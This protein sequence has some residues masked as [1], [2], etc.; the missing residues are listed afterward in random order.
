MKNDQSPNLPSP[1][2]VVLIA[3]VGNRNVTYELAGQ[4]ISLPDLFKNEGLHFDFRA[5]TRQLVQEWSDRPLDTLSPFGIQIF[6]AHLSTNVVAAHLFVT[7]QKTAD[8]P[9]GHHQDTLYAGEL[10]QRV[11]TEQ[12]E[13]PTT[14]HRYTGDPTNDD[15]V[16]GFMAPELRAVVA[17][18]PASEYELRFV[19]AGGTPG[20]K[21]VAKSLLRYY[22]PE[23]DIVY[24]PQ[25]GKARAAAHQQHDRYVLLSVARQFVHTYQYRAAHN[26][27]VSQASGALFQP[28]LLA[29]LQVAAFRKTFN[30]ATA[31]KVGIGP[32]PAVFTDY[33][34]AAPVLSKNLVNFP[35]D[36]SQE[37]RVDI[38][39]LASLTALHL[40]Q[41]QYEVAI[42]TYYRLCEEI[43]QC[44]AEHKGFSLR[45]KNDK[46][47]FIA[48]TQEAVKKQY[49]GLD[50]YGVPYLLG[51]ALATCSNKLLPVI[52]E[53]TRTISH[54]NGTPKRH[55]DP[56]KSQEEKGLNVLR[57]DCFL[58]HGNRPITK[59]AIEA[60]SPGFLGASGRAARI[61]QLLGLP[62]VNVYDQMNTEI[63]SLFDQE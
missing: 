4:E 2:S 58:A 22:R 32:L 10:C 38:V 25:A 59:D 36:F 8:F 63:L 52:Q 53:L 24:T 44:F 46:D 42:P 6:A 12:Y 15:A 45:G 7:D 49:A 29:L 47:R 19:D 61:F 5:R 39:E 56:R 14:L 20:M 50:R 48:T 13:T 57:N 33:L 30:R 16:Y 60:E 40:S 34:M 3:N 51:Y 26:V 18:Y 21:T 11:L 35:E 23:V 28:Q 37:Q 43:G 31:R 54:V 55:S 17:D 1:K 62:A 9:D 41:G 27:L